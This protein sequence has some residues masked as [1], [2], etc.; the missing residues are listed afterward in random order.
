MAKKNRSVTVK[1][2]PKVQRKK[3]E[4]IGTSGGFLFMGAYVLIT[5]NIP[6]TFVGWAAFIGLFV[7]VSA[8]IYIIAHFIVKNKQLK[9]AAKAVASTS[10]K[11]K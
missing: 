10:S 2:K 6:E 1:E 9:N 8:V 5:G 7:L 3:A 11:R 4:T